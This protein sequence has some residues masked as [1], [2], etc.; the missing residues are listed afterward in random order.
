MMNSRQPSNINLELELL[1]TLVR[2]APVA[3]TL[4]K[5]PLFTIEITNDKAL[6]LWGKQY[7]DVIHQPVLTVFPELEEHG[8]GQI[9]QHVLST[10]EPF[11]AHELPVKITR[12]GRTQTLFVNFRYEPLR[13]SDNEI[14]GV[15]GFETDVTEEV[16]SR[17]TV[18]ENERRSF[19][20][21]AQAAVGIT[22]YQGDDLTVLVAN[23]SACEVW[24]KSQ[25]ELLGKPVLEISPEL[26]H[27][28][29]LQIVRQVLKTGVPFEGREV[30]I[31]F[32]RNG[33]PYTGYYDV[34]YTAWKGSQGEI[35]GVI[36][37]YTE[38]THSV[39]ARKKSEEKEEQLRIALEGGDLGYFDY[40]PQ[41][42]ELI[43]SNRL[44]QMFGLPVDTKASLDIFFNVLHPEDRE[45]ANK[46]I[47][48]ALD[49]AYGGIYDNEYRVVSISDGKVRWL[50]SRGKTSFDE[51][52][53]PAR[54]TGVIRDITPEKLAEEAVRE[55]EERFR[56]TFENAAV[57]IAHVDLNGTWLMVN[58]RLCEIAG[59]TREE[60]L[61]KTFQE[62]TH[63]HDL[64]ADLH[65]V[66]GLLSGRLKTY[67]MEKR[68]IR[69][70]GSFI[71]VN[72][73]V[74]LAKKRDG[75]PDYFIA[76]I[77]DISEQKRTEE[78]VKQR[79]EQF[80]TLANNIQNLAWMADS[81]GTILWYN[82]RWYDYTGT[83]PQQMANKSWESFHHP[84]YV[85]HV[86]QLKT[87]LHQGEPFELTFP[88]RRHDGN[89]RWFLTRVYPIKGAGGEVLRWVGTSTD[90]DEHKS[91]E[92]R[93]ENLVAERTRQLKRS[94]EELQQFAHVASHDFKEPVRKIR[95]FSNHLSSEYGQF[96]PEKGKIYLDKIQDA[97]ARIYEMID[98]ILLYSSFEENDRLNESVNLTTVIRQIMTD[99]EL[100]IQDKNAK[101]E[102]GELPTIQGSSV[103]FYQLF[104][105]LIN[106]ALKFS[107]PNVPPVIT[108]T[109][110]QAG[111]DKVQITLQDNGIGFKES[112]ADIIFKA[113]SRLHA[114]S[115][116]QGTGLGLS[117][118]KRI[119]ERHGGEI[120]AHGKEGV[121]AVFVIQLPVS[122]HYSPGA[123]FAPE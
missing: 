122:R 49:P 29:A 86:N 80:R 31:D 53:I 2:Q 103:L 25:E 113:F 116:F 97:S 22:V 56:S 115:E 117:L 70:N 105:N 87:A 111:K 26:E 78:E 118:C 19:E 120:Y 102:F 123:V 88:L 92:E 3:M 36:T 69:K 79:E 107:K 85:D 41:T 20:L 91:V 35:K 5:G 94:N 50:H 121:G 101:I 16:A 21:L 34:V 57:G 93:L 38:V 8:F 73:T 42:G 13:T 45:P 54:F 119:V 24:G 60:L 96:L 9:L 40:R 98:A 14:I 51:A 33:Q 83:T 62:I 46:R 99:L 59:Y 1:H 90:I 82:Q 27:S 52:N 47:Q 28:P 11:M 108:I 12:G 18:G 95:I 68:Y 114:K 89:Y 84:Q 30:A 77:Q 65:F 6:E 67:S 7:K 61:A 76:V 39:L 10:G 104:S 48:E 110:E 106:N 55:S 66:A 37:V 32:I 112:Y 23:Q 100:A 71:W 58:D 4:L 63:P 72:L 44:L 74:S 109:W 75:S 15:I 81:A 17:K 64:D 43:M